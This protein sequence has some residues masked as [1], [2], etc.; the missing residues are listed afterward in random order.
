LKAHKQKNNFHQDIGVKQGL[1]T[2][3]KNK[4][5][6]YKQM[7][8]TKSCT[9]AKAVLEKQNGNTVTKKYDR[10][11]PDVSNKMLKT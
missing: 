7:F 11:T 2:K 9:D 6:T 3:T 5:S 4:F 10:A 8:V 1:K